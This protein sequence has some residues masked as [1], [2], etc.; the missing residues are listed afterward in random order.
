MS[1]RSCTASYCTW[2][3][4]VEWFEC[5]PSQLRLAHLLSYSLQSLFSKRTLYCGIALVSLHFHLSIV[6]TL[7]RTPVSQVTP[8]WRKPRRSSHRA[9]SPHRVNRIRRLE[10]TESRQRG[11][12]KTATSQMRNG[13]TPKRISCLTRW[14]TWRR[15]ARLTRMASEKRL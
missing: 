12:Q 3:I 10:N 8:Q 9:L 13:T 4:I 5:L 6:K 7:D 11:D 14:Q 2:P 1:P 15:G